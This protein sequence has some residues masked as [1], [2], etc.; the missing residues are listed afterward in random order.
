MFRSFLERTC[1]WKNARQAARR[2]RQRLAHARFR[3]RL[4]VQQLE[5]R[6]LLSISLLGSPPTWVEQGPG[7]V[8]GYGGNPANGGLNST[9]PTSVGAIESTAVEPT[10]TGYIV[11]A[12]TVNGGIWR[13]DNITSGMFD[14]SADP[15]Q[16]A[17]RPLTDNV[18]SSNG[19]PLSLATSSMALDPNDPTGNTLWVGTGSVSSYF[20]F[21]GQGIGLL[22]TT[23]GGNTWSILGQDVFGAHPGGDPRGEQILCVLPTTLTDT[24]SGPGHGGQ[25][26]LVASYQTGLYYSGDGGQTFTNVL[27]GGATGI[28]EDPN[29]PNTF[30]ASFAGGPGGQG[31]IF[32]S[33]DDGQDWGFLLASTSDMTTSPNLKLAASTDPASHHT[34]L[35]VAT[36]QTVYRS[37]VTTV[38]DSFTP[39]GP[40]PYDPVDKFDGVQALSITADPNDPNTAYVAK[41]GELLLRFTYSPGPAPNGTAALLDS[42]YLK[43][44]AQLTNNTQYITDYNSLVSASKTYPHGDFRSLTLLSSNTLL[45]TDDG[46]IYGVNGV[47]NAAKQFQDSQSVVD[48]APGPGWVSI[49]GGGLSGAPG[50]RG[51]EFF[52][53]AYDTRNGLIL[54]GAQDNG[55]ALQGPGPSSSLN[56]TSRLGGDGFLTAV[57][58]TTIPNNVLDPTLYAVGNPGIPFKVSESRQGYPPPGA[59]AT[60][61]NPFGML[62]LASPTDPTPYSGLN[63]TDQ[64]TMNSATTDGSGEDFIQYALNTQSGITDPEPMLY[65]MTGI[66][67]S[68]DGGDH[69][70]DVSPPGMSGVVTSLAYGSQNSGLAAY[71]ATRPTGQSG[72]IWV[73]NDLAQNLPSQTFAL[74]P[75][76]NWGNA[77]ALKIVMDPADYHFAYVLDSSNQVWQLQF[78]DNGQPTTNGGTVPVQDATWTNITGTLSNL[79]SIDGTINLQALEVYHPTSGNPVVLVGGLGGV[80][81]GLPIGPSNNGSGGYVWNLYGAVPGGASV[82]NVLVTDLHYIPIPADTFDYGSDGD[83]LLAG[84][85]GR[86]AWIVP[87]ASATLAQPATLVINDDPGVPNVIRLALDAASTNSPLL[88]V[89]QNNPTETP[90][91][92]IPLAELD[93]IQVNSLDIETTLIVDESNGVISTPVQ[94]AGGSGSDTLFVDAH[95]D[96]SIENV[97]LGTD[98]ILGL[99]GGTFY[100]NA[101]YVQLAG[102]T[103]HGNAYILANSDPAAQTELDT[104]P[105]GN[106]VFVQQTVGAV[107]INCG[108][109]DVVQVG[110]G[111]GLQDIHGAMK[112]NG[113]FDEPSLDLSDIGDSSDLTFTVTDSTVTNLAPAL[114]QY[115]LL[116]NLDITTGS[117][118][119]E[120]VVQNTAPPI[121]LFGNPLKSTNTSIGPGPGGTLVAQVDAT[122]SPL[123]IFGAFLVQVGNGTVQNILG[124]VLIEQVQGTSPVT[125]LVEDGADTQ[126]EQAQLG[127]ASS[128]D[129][130]ITGLAPAPIAFGSGVDPTVEFFGP[131]GTFTVNDTPPGAI[132]KIESS[133]TVDVLGTTGSLGVE[134]GT[135]VNVGGANSGLTALQGP[136]AVSGAAT[137]DYLDQGTTPGQTLSY[138]VSAN[139]LS[140]TGTATVTYGGIASVNINA[141]NAASAGFNTFYIETTA[142]GTAYNVYAGSSG[143]TE[144]AVSNNSSLDAMQ[145]VLNLHGQLASGANDFA[146]VSDFLNPVVHTYT[147]STGE[148]Q[149]DGTSP[150]FYDGLS[151]WE[152]YA[153]Q[154]ADAVNIESVG[155][156]VSTVLAANTGS[157]VTVG[158]PTAGGGHTLQNILSSLLV[159]ATSSPGPTVLIDDSG[160]PSTAARTV[161]FN[162]DPYGYR[163]HNL[164]PG[165]IYLQPGTSSAVTVKGDGG[166]ETFAFKDLP[167][168]MQMTLDGNAG[169]NTLD[170]SQYVGDVT[171]DLPKS[172]ATGLTGGIRN[173]QN[174]TGSQGNDLIVGDA[175]A[176][177][178][179]GGTGRNILIG[180]TGADTLDASG[181]TSDNILIGGTTN[182][183]TDLLALDAI[184]NEWTRIDLGFL[185]RFSDL[186]KV[187]NSTGKKPLNVVGLK[188]IL[189]TPDTVQ[190]NPSSDT[191]TGGYQNDPATGQRLHN[192]FICDFDVDDTI[193]NF[194]ASSDK[195]TKLH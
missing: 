17:W 3:Q 120:A 134:F 53:V 179:K 129:Y 7:P 37:D 4:A 6:T 171:V 78:T 76:P 32:K 96:I 116:Q 166:N 182:F 172:F 74:L 99:G 106:R 124:P 140:R 45:E 71:V 49:N 79:A 11:Y 104:G 42:L 114:I 105:R 194:L 58:P 160:N 33:N 176:N 110:D 118:H 68:I 156:G 181:A 126:G 13:S 52:S 174:V 69:V 85:F 18:L 93:L 22:K 144:F 195:K 101:N 125:L 39:V 67:E 108:G 184:L 98:Q 169:T 102:G 21:G 192:W 12:G 97:T 10:A 100:T 23:D 103:A 146:I 75:P 133:G 186:T 153:G 1:S 123:T 185:D 170:Y 162:N 54:G 44:L 63:P 50:I 191:L 92:Q 55:T 73:R 157:T 91:F 81:R 117:G 43:D 150:I 27:S 188:L 145:G 80:Y 57:D 60:A 136:L 41:F 161:T 122:Q 40:S 121:T 59:F 35:W 178:L 130:A 36:T 165:D 142:P 152:V 154:R 180:G 86:G 112:V 56:W 87:Q 168:N 128:L 8:V 141:A 15:S 148:F 89:F 5:H 38:T 107:T 149:R 164:A 177:V 25:V 34:I 190:A 138:T 26:V 95:K 48:L 62:A 167:A 20:R 83:V 115:N 139:Q 111:N 64:Q 28:V 109:P 143:V 90:N 51:T 65:G 30:Y 151:L 187:T 70:T 16:A 72:Q 82:P 163:I 189:L 14:G 9:P 183:D 29:A 2:R 132:T 175:N 61:A 94:F 47:Q 193:K 137:L 135:L 77:Y 155:A 119:D 88:D 159:V 173:I 131:G 158:T 147:L 24:G 113:I 46:G 66:Y 127:K 84:T 31:G 19:Q